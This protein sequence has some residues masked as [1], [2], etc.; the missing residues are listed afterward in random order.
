MN[1]IFLNFSIGS[2]TGKI[3]IPTGTGPFPTIIIFDTGL[4]KITETYA[5]FYAK[6]MKEIG[7]SVFIIKLN[8]NKK[9][10]IGSTIEYILSREEVNSN[11]IYLIEIEKNN[12]IDFNM[13]SYKNYFQ[14]ITSI[15]CFSLNS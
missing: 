1:D 13:E 3:Y 9:N 11:K 7:F 5:T 10:E 4:I 12:L 2:A 6:K 14:A 15:N 8:L